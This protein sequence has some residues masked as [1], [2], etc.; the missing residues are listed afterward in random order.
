MTFS[1]HRLPHVSAEPVSI[2]WNGRSVRGLQGDT[3]AALLYGQGVRAFT[4]SRKFHQPRGLSGA[5][6]AGHLAAVNGVP[7]CRLDRITT[8]L[9]QRVKTE[10]VWPSAGFDLLNM[11]RLLP[12][13]MS[14]A[15]FEHP[16]FI[17]DS[18]PAWKLW[19]KLLWHIAGEADPPQVGNRSAIS[20]RQIVCD[21]LVIGGGPAGLAAAEAASGSVVIVTRSSELGDMTCGIEAAS[22]GLPERVTVLT[23]HE[24]YG[25]FGNGRIAMAAANDPQQPAVMIKARRVI[26][27]TGVRS[28]PPLVPGAALPGVLDARTALQLAARHG[29]APGRQVLVMGTPMGRAVAARLSE[30]GC[31]ILDFIDASDVERINGRGSVSSVRA[32]GRD[33]ACDSVV[34]AGP[35]R[36]DPSLAFQAGADGDLRLM[37]GALPAHVSLQGACSEPGEAISFGRALDRRALVCPCMDVTVDEVLDLIDLGITHVEEL[38]RRTTCGM[39]TCQGVPCWDYLGAVVADATGRSLE[40]IGHPTYRPPRAALTIG[41]AAGLADITEIEA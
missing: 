4:R 14:R 24:V 19:E 32:G 3:V 23:D 37:P 25:L 6:A 26:L 22:T 27:A 17:P 12:R 1:E 16:R 15:G 40:D 2:F 33:L 5:F 7:H 41:Q 21:A 35:W 11:A 39:G 9:G 36:P 20:G 10:N 38:K 18:S 31:N 30:L 8:K 34:H 13:R 28:V 29:V